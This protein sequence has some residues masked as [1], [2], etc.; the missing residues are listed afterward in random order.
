M[1]V[2][3][4]FLSDTVAAQIH[5]LGQAAYTLEAEQIGCADFPP[6]RETIGDFLRCSDTFLLFEESGAIV[7]ALSF[8][9]RECDV[10]ITRLIV[11]PGKM[12]RGIAT[13]LLDAFDRRLPAKA[14]VHVTTAEANTPAI[15]LYQRRGFAHQSASRSPEGI[16][17]VHFRRPPAGGAGGRRLYGPIGRGSGDGRRFKSRS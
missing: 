15:S 14:C 1:I 8:A 17:L 5:A 16:G 2:E 10:T 4:I 6:L 9:M 12:R 13:A 3:V 11:S 7:G